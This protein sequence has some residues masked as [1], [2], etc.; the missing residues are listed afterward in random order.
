[1]KIYALVIEDWVDDYTDS[2]YTSLIYQGFYATKDLAQKA[3]KKKLGGQGVVREV[4]VEGLGV[5]VMF[6]HKVGGLLFGG[7]FSTQEK[8]DKIKKKWNKKN[9]SADCFA[10]YINVTDEIDDEFILGIK[11]E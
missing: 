10:D 2:G 1:M 7:V 9:E 3:N 8:A 6:I 4:V 11:C 5:Y